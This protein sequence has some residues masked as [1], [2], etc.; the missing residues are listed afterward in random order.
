VFVRWKSRK[1]SYSG[2]WHWLAERVTHY[3]V[4]VESTRVDGKPRQRFV[5]HLANYHEGGRVEYY[6]HVDF[7]RQVERRLKS[8]NL[9]ADVR[10]RVERKLAERVPRPTPELLA[11]LSRRTAEFNAQIFGG[12]DRVPKIVS[13]CEY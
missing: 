1:S 12:K 7:W 9:A 3:A 2:R 11:E 13:D 8:L 6:P 5:A 10:E 4:L